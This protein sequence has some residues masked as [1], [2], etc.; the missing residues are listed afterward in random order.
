MIGWPP[1]ISEVDPIYDVG[2]G[3]RWEIVGSNPS[4]SQKRT[5]SSIASPTSVGSGGGGGRVR[6]ASRAPNFS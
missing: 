4:N 6:V 2:K 3:Y 5:S 1:P